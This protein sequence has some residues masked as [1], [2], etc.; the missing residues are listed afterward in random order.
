MMIFEIPHHHKYYHTYFVIFQF[1]WNAINLQDKCI[2][3][4]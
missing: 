1:M 2:V 4:N 3:I